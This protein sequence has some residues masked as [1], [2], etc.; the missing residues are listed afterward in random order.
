MALARNFGLRS[1]RSSAGPA[2][3][4]VSVCLAD[5]ERTPNHS[6]GFWGDGHKGFPEALLEA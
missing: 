5:L 4:F 1:R 2:R 3:T 6:P